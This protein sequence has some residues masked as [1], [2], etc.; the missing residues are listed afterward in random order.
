MIKSLENP[1]EVQF[2]EKYFFDMDE[3][4]KG[5]VFGKILAFTS[6][7]GHVLTME[8]LLDDG[9]VFSYVPLMAISGL[10]DELSLSETYYFN[11]P[12]GEFFVH[13]LTHLKTK[14]AWIYD[15]N[16]KR[17]KAG[18]YILTVDWPD[19]NKQG[20][21]ITL[22]GSLILWPSHKILFRD[23]EDYPEEDALPGYEKM[24]K[25]WKL[26]ERK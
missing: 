5:Y 22:S 17:G 25:E 18:K 15:R 21:L 6:Y 2:R 14:L 9:A 12:D 4:K 11:C 19:A 20:H 8:V 7:P 26:P 16:K 13:E 24:H 1:L 3:R 10:G 23:H